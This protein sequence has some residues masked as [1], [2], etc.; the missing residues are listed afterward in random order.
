[1]KVDGSFA[2]IMRGVSQQVPEL[3]LD[4]QHTEQLNMVS[5]PVTGLARRRGTNSVVD[6]PLGPYA[7]TENTAEDYAGF[8]TKSY[9]VATDEFDILYRTGPMVPASNAPLLHCFNKE[10]NTLLPLVIP[11]GEYGGV[12]AI[13]G[14][15]VSAV[16]QVGR[17]LLF[18]PVN[19]PSDGSATDNYSVAS[20][21]RYAAIWIRGGVYSRKYSITI[22]RTGTDITVEYTTPSS[23]YT[24]TLDTS[25]IPY[26]ATDYQKQ[27]NDRVNT[28]NSN[29]TA[30]LVSSSAAVQPAAIAE[31]LKALLITA[32]ITPVRSGSHL[33]FDDVS[34]T[35]ISL[36]D[37]GDGTLMRSVHQ[38]VTEAAQV[39]NVHAVG[40]IV[41]VQP[42]QDDPAY[43][44][45]AIPKDPGATGFAE[46]TW[47]EAAS[48]SFTPGLWFAIGT[49]E[50]GSMYL[51]TSPAAMRAAIP[52]LDIPDI[53]N[54]VVGD[55]DSNKAPYFVGKN[56]TYMG[57]FQDRLVIGAGNVVSMSEVGN[58]FNFFRT[59]VLTVLDSD[60]V[61]V[62]ATGSDN[63]VLRRSVVFDKSLLLFG[64]QAQYSLSGRVPITPATTAILPS[65]YHEAAA[66]ADPVVSGD[67]V[68]YTKSRENYTQAYQLAIGDVS[69]TS[70]STEVSQQLD[71]YIPGT[72]VEVV[73]TTSP[74]MLII[75]TSE[76]PSDLFVYSYLDARGG[77]ERLFDSWGKW[78]FDSRLGQQIGMSAYQGGVL[79]YYI[80]DGVDAGGTARTWLSVDKVSLLAERDSKPYLDSARSTAAVTAGDTTRPWH[81]QDWLS[82][83]YDMGTAT[84]PNSARLQGVVGMAGVPQLIT[85]MAGAPGLT[86]GTQFESSVTLTN[87]RKRNRDGIAIM[88]GRLTL[89]QYSVTFAN[90]AGF[91]CSVRTAYNDA[92]VLDFNGRMLGAL[93]N[94]VAVQPVSNGSLSAFVGREVRDFDFTITSRTWMPLTITG[95]AWVGQFFNN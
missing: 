7:M 86:T 75:R 9:A 89:T 36:N 91:T 80:R 49:V 28:Y 84:A 31:S 50:A 71:T 61:E 72:P 79:L 52:G 29:V 85:E 77:R 13:L 67:L 93:N 2:S 54:R 60:P 73:A 87:P 43:Y 4:G 12:A 17:Y 64:D 38:V 78:T 95:V 82:S 68:F 33:L 19:F 70:D 34:I 18:A 74:N 45:K 6:I 83:A 8:R 40:K 25:D 15:G 10:T 5:D 21:S 46:V 27:V 94:I 69:D 37:G 57:T 1:M 47:E 22:H 62:F 24:G 23:A 81:T 20:N 26:A 88:S 65:S 92:V 90:T 35:G 56:I 66:Q 58:Y 42:R 63:D 51:T 44:L 41:K 76:H 39:T 59:S 32:G 3:R 53:S 48:H 30:W 55:P 14:S 11:V 16:T